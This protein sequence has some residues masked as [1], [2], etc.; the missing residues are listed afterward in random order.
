M[1]PFRL[2][3]CG[4]EELAHYRGLGV[5]HVIS[6][7]DPGYPAPADWESHSGEARLELRFHDVIDET[8]GMIAPAESHIETIVG[9]GS[10]LPREPSAGHHLL[11]HCHAGIS[12]ST[13]TA[14]LLL[15]S[16]RP[17]RSARDIFGAVA[18]IRPPAWP[19]LRMIEMGDAL[20]DRGG[21]LAAALR[22]RY[23]AVLARDPGWADY[24]RAEGRQRELDFASAPGGDEDRGLEAAD[25]APT[26]RAAR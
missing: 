23:R 17:E 20:L 8:E 9:F 24:M 5:S 6:I 2:S 10:S 11:I 13:A 19:N 1:T 15:A 26:S 25:G 16:A 3:I 21:D 12:R 7:L 22:A 14:V 4:L 18:K